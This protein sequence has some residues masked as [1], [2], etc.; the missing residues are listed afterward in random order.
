MYLLAHV[1]FRWRNLHTLNKQRLVCAVLVV[2]LMPLAVEIP[3]L[4]LVAV[5]A[6]VLTALIAYETLRFAEAREPH[7][8]RAGARHRQRTSGASDRPPLPFPGRWPSPSKNSRTRAP[9]SAAPSTR[10]PSRP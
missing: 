5:L 2:A 4:V 6:A 10:R 8:P 7:P 9:T 1:A 3:A